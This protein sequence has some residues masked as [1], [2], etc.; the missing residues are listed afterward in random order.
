[1]LKRVS[2]VAGNRVSMAK[3]GEIL[4]SQ[5]RSKF[6]SAKLRANAGL[7]LF[8]A[9]YTRTLSYRTRYVYCQKAES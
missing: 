9:S 5:S 2:G 6:Y 3:T 1:M 8:P 7:F 4:L